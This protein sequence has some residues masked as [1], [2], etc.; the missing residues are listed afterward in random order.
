MQLVGGGL[1]GGATS[2]PAG[3]FDSLLEAAYQYDRETVMEIFQRWWAELG[4][5]AFLKAR[6]APLAQEIGAAWVEGRLDIRHEHFLT[7]LMQDTLRSLRMPLEP[8]AAGRPLLLATLPGERHA[9]GLQMAALTSTIVRRRVRLLG[10]ECPIAELLET[11]FRLNAAAVGITVTGSSAFP[12][13]L[14]AIGELRAKLPSAIQLWI[15]G[16][17]AKLLGD[18]PGG[19]LVLPTLDGLERALESLE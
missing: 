12:E 9:L 13:T 2:L 10:T 1:F 5:S 11:A 8:S 18:L 17:G 16:A 15:G 3:Q 4:L 19:V 7:E 14:L 6:M